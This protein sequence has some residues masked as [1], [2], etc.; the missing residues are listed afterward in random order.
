MGNGYGSALFESFQLNLP[1]FY[2][3]QLRTEVGW[4]ENESVQQTKFKRISREII[5]KN[6]LMTQ[7][8]NVRFLIDLWLNS[9]L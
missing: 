8:K 2:E 9:E 1:Q 6:Q 3:I 4:P 7:V 5:G